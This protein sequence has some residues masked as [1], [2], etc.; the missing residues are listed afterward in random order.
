MFRAIP[1]PIIGSF[2]LYI[3]HWY[4]SCSYD[5][6]FQARLVVIESLMYS[7]K[8]PMMGRGIARNM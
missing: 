4:M 1:L 7:G 8:L 3:R 2:P 5:N 6:S